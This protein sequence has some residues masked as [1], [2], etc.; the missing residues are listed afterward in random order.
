MTNKVYILSTNQNKEVI[1]LIRTTSP[2]YLSPYQVYSL[3][4][5]ESDIFKM[6]SM[7][8]TEYFYVVVTN[9]ALSFSSFNFD[10]VPKEW[11]NKYMHIWNNDTTLRLFNKHEVMNNPN[12]Y[13]DNRLAA[14]NVQIKNHIGKTYDYPVL[15]IVFISYDETLAEEHYIALSKRF[16][17]ALRSHGVKGICEAH[18]AAAN[19]ANTDMFYVVDADAIILDEFDFSYQ[20]TIYDR[21]SV[22]VWH[23]INAVNGLE[24]GYGGVKLFPTKLLQDYRGSA[25][26]FTTSVSPHF[27]VMEYRS[28]I[29][30]FN[31]DPF[32]AWR[33]G[34]RE[35]VKLGSNLIVNGNDQDTE[36]RLDIWCTKG[37]D[38]EFG[39]FTIL[40][41]NEGMAFGKKHANQP[42]LLGL[43]NDAKWLENTF[44]T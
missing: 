44:S 13:S 41:A 33:S 6:A 10:Y 8:T 27:K 25:I 28:N 14:G 16:P 36:Y 31:T 22:H 4:I 38:M 21:K 11:D 15:D 5:K 1:D 23:S 19:I 35:C 37:N 17:R 7:S 9:N 32:S 18:I 12:A 29:T 42:E 43:I 20:P 24:Y 34:F 26:D 30:K 39:E 3:N 40:G 2:I